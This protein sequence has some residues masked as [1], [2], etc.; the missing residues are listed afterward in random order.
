MSYETQK[1]REKNEKNFQHPNKDGWEEPSGPAGYETD[2]YG[3]L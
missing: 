2:S 1:N 3:V